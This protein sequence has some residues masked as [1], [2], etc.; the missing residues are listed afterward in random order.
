[1]DK[2]EILALP[3]TQ[4]TID[5]L[6][7]LI[8]TSFDQE[9][10]LI[11]RI[12]LAEILESDQH[13]KE[14]IHLLLPTLETFTHQKDKD[15][16]FTILNI[17]IRCHIKLE[18]QE[19]ALKYITLKKEA[20]PILEGHLYLEDLVSY[21]EAFKM[22][23]DNEVEALLDAPVPKHR[24]IELL[25]S[26]IE[27]NKNDNTQKVLED[28]NKI[29]ALNPSKEELSLL[30]EIELEIDFQNGEYDKIINFLKEDLRPLSI[31]YQI[32]SHIKLEN[33]KQA[34]ILEVEY[35]HLFTELSIHKQQHLFETLRDFYTS[36]SDLRSIELYEEKLKK[37][38]RTLKKQDKEDIKE[39]HVPIFNIP[40]PKKTPKI[41]EEESPKPKITSSLKDQRTLSHI[42]Q[43]LT[44]VLTINK[45]LDRHEY[46]RQLFMTMEKH[47][48]FSDL[49]LYESPRLYHYKKGRLYEKQIDRHMIDASIVGIAANDYK[50]IIEK[51]E[52]LKYN[53]DI[54][55]QKPLSE[56]NIKNV[57]CYALPNK[58]S[59][60]FYQS[61]DKALIYDDMSLKIASQTLA[62]EFSFYQALLRERSRS[63]NLR[64]LFQSKA[65]GMSIKS[66]GRFLFNDTLLEYLPLRRR[67]SFEQIYEYL[68]PKD[69]I[70]LKDQMG[71]LERGEIDFFSE[72][73]FVLN[74]H[75]RIQQT[76]HKDSVFGFYSDITSDVKNIENWKEKALF[77]L[78]SEL[79]TLS[80]F[81]RRFND[82]IKG[83]VTFILASLQDLENIEFIYGKALALAYFLEFGKL[84][85]MRFERVYHFDSNTILIEI[86]QNDIRAIE[87]HIKSFLKDLEDTK[88][89]TLEDQPFKTYLGII[90][91]P[92]NTRETDIKKIYA[93]LSFSLLRA[94]HS[95]SG[96]NHSYFNFESYLQEVHETE[97][98]KQIDRLITT[99]SLDITFNQIANQQTNLVYAYEIEPFSDT[100]HIEAD[101]YHQ[102][103][104]RRDQTEKLERYL[105]I[106]AFKR[107]SSIYNETNKYIKLSVTLSPKTIR[108]RLFNPFLIGLYKTYN[109]PY[110]I[111][112]IIVSMKDGKVAD[113]EKM[114]ELHDLGIL[115]GTDH[116]NFIK[117]PQ[118]KIFHLKDRPSELTDRFLNAVKHLK[119][120]TDDEDIALVIYHVDRIKE[121][122]LLKS[123]GI[124]YIRGKTVD[125]K[126]TYEELLKLIKGV[127]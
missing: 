107:L 9:E 27:R 113:Y 53:Y 91:Y 2:N 117:E 15:D 93:Y 54:I 119:M 10:V 40:K 95:Y 127:K 112:D 84:A 58:S 12:K 79:Y 126:Y 124:D 102:V 43:Y 116:Y 64:D 61:T 82:I 122:T 45:Q 60:C 20:L 3:Y 106:T 31:Y 105:L 89:T 80:E 78:H 121:R 100:L 109:I 76:K 13:F 74:K 37:V 46:H 25:L 41:I 123:L 85:K 69:A 55:S 1:M 94:K 73:V 75:I 42:D 33:T 125:R 114:K 23:Y 36:T 81:E 104:F 6:Y 111:V 28:I 44:E 86:P 87:N 97:I 56:T 68:E 24:K 39:P 65:M 108:D 72:D 77:D 21:K 8:H 103:A 59:L 49:I 67:E 90:R 51:V 5:N 47:F 30:W 14:V 16:Y 48:D 101:Y 11:A 7:D 63:E 66:N 70:K 71:M 29:I 52:Y 26:R 38:E 17:L 22:D 88:S 99:E 50:D 19:N 35:E 115:I 18:D 4:E 120:Y 57:Y 32:L 98:I 118:T 34:S 96:Y 83:K 110:H 92:I 62:Y